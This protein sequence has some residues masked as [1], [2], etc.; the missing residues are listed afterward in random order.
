MNNNNEKITIQVRTKD[1]QDTP[2]FYEISKNTY[3]FLID[4]N[5]DFYLL[6]DDIIIEKVDLNNIKKY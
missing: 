2:Q 6:N 4:L 1:P 3:D 5:N